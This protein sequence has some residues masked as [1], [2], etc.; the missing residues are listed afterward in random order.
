M[1]GKVTCNTGQYIKEHIKEKLGHAFDLMNIK[2]QTEAG[3]GQ[4]DQNKMIPIL[5]ELK[6]STAIWISIPV[7]V[8][9]H[10]NLT[11]FLCF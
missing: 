4:K 2:Y 10:H 1:E 5:Y 7:S 8:I 9:L 6:Q 3:E 11:R